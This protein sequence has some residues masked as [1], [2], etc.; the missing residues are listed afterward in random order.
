M[1]YRDRGFKVYR[2]ISIYIYMCVCIYTR[3]D[4]H[5][6]TYHACMHACIRV[7]VIKILPKATVT[8]IWVVTMGVR[9]SVI[10]NGMP[11]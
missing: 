7:I 5:I 8:R 11:T 2:D 6:R 1:D 3:I 9:V 10:P 4:L